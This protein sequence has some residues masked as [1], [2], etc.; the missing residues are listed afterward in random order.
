MV[1]TLS[2]LT[3]GVTAQKIDRRLTQLVELSKHTMG[4]RAHDASALDTAGIKKDFNVTFHTDGTIDRI[5]AIATL[6]PGAMLPAEQLERMGIKACQIV[7]DMVVLDIPADRLQQL[8]Q[9]EEF[10]YVEADEMIEANNDLARNDTKVT[11]VSTLDKA[12][13]EGLPQAYTGAGI[14]VGVIDTGIDFNHASFL[15]HDG[16]TRIKKAFIFNRSEKT[17]YNTEDEIKRLT[18]DNTSSSHGSHTSAIAAGSETSV[19]TQGMAPEAELVL[20]GLGR[21]APSS[22]FVQG[23]KDI[24]TY[25]DQVNKPAVINISFGNNIGLHDGSN[26]V[27]KTVSELTENGTKPGRAVIISS[28]NDA[29]SQKSISKKLRAG[30][31]LK[32]VLGATTAPNERYPAHDVEYNLNCY[33]YADDYKDF[34]LQLKVVNV[35]NG[36]IE[37]VGTHVL[38]YKDNV[39]TPKLQK[40]LDVPTTKGVTAVTYTLYCNNIHMDDRNLRLMLVAKAGTD[41]QTLRMMRMGRN[42]AEPW[43]DAPTDKG[44]NFAENG[45]TKG[46]GEFSFNSMICSDAV[47]SVGSYIT[48]NQWYN[49]LGE[50]YSCPTSSLTGKKQQVGEISDFSSYAVGDDNGKPYPTLI[51]PG[52]RIVSA[53][54]NYDTD[55]F[56]DGSPGQLNSQRR[57]RS[58][59]VKCLTEFDRDN[60]YIQ[61]QGTSMS[62]PVVTGIVAL[63]MQ[64]DPK[65]TVNRIKEIMKETCDNDQWT[66]DV[67]FIPSGHKEQAGYGKVNCLKGLKKILG[68]TPVEAISIDGHRGATPATMYS[69]DA[70]VYNLNGQRVNKNHRGLVVYKGR[71]Y[72]NK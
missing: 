42:S 39:Y 72:I 49:Y 9:M 31:E 29:K 48:R 20:V 69:V 45:Y 62:T 8:E 2:L 47:I 52:H 25:A 18:T 36:K 15:T 71:V 40:Q 60:W 6:K 3:T 10:C 14:V 22:S 33:F 28:S 5:S 21:T 11:N 68:T 4:T 54:N 55:Y 41:G 64:A 53:A 63:W 30:E 66:T 58:K 57:I 19:N 44:Y 27:A 65:L 23:I 46:S 70:L 35:T 13:V 26:L 24:F 43:L 17:E 7:S 12:R 59:V 50:S 38:D 51:A 34:D 1:L 37:E 67:A 61:L 56:V 16:A 32:T